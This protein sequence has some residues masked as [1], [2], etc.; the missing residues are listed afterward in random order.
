MSDIK[1]ER[2]TLP[3]SAPPSEMWTQQMVAS[4]MWTH[5]AVPAAFVTDPERIADML[6]ADADALA[7]FRTEFLPEGVWLTTCAELPGLVV[8]TD[9]REEG[10]RLATE[11]A[12]DLLASEKDYGI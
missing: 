9:T 7:A 1:I 12:A 6:D 5:H 4:E 11:V 8:E 3:P 10:E 2:Q